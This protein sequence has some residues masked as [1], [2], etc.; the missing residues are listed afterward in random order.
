MGGHLGE[1]RRHYHNKGPFI[2]TQ[3]LPTAAAAPRGG[4]K[5]SPWSAVTPITPAKPSL[6]DAAADLRSSSPAAW[7]GCRTKEEPLPPLL[8]LKSITLAFTF[9]VLPPSLASSPIESPALLLRSPPVGAQLWMQCLCCWDDN[10]VTL[11]QVHLVSR[12]V[13]EFSCIP[14]GSYA[15]RTLR[16]IRHVLEWAT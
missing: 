10:R 1:K 2:C 16:D 11:A 8:Y 12:R 5:T 13:N 4:K 3:A 7:T 9:S 15:L 14:R 6:S